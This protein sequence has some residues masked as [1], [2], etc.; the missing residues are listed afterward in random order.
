MVRSPASAAS[1]SFS[2][3]AP[4]SGATSSVPRRKRRAAPI[5]PCASS[6]VKRPSNASRS[7]AV[8]RAEGRSAAA[9]VTS[10]SMSDL[11][12]AAARLSAAA[13][14]SADTAAAEVA[15]P[16][17]RAALPVS[18]SKSAFRA[19]V[20]RSVTRVKM[21]GALIAAAMPA[22]TASATSIRFMARLP[23]SPSVIAEPAKRVRQG[24]PD[25]RSH[26]PSSI[27]PTSQRFSSISAS[28][29]AT[30]RHAVSATSP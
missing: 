11:L 20:E 8:R 7:S 13:R 3:Q 16:R 5:A 29:V 12:A 28:S 17:S 14:S 4:Y 25:D 15:A 18:S 21:A 24:I 2:Y 1:G 9:S 26:I 10:A 6:S 19:P 30:G 22:P 27:K 23:R